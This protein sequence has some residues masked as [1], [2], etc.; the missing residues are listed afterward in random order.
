MIHVRKILEKSRLKSCTTT[1]D[2]S[3]NLVLLA[4]LM[5]LPRRPTT[6]T[7]RFIPGMFHAMS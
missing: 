7:L 6:D 3:P 1:D 2:R 5:V 4:S